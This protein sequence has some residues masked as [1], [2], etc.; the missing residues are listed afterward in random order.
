MVKN[1]VCIH[2]LEWEVFENTFWKF[3]LAGQICYS[4]NRTEDKRCSAY[5][6]PIYALDLNGF[7]SV[8]LYGVKDS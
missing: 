8:P 5:A 6:K 4:W 2:K 1:E 7:N 3:H